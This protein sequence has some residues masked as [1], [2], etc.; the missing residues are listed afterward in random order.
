MYEPYWTIID[1]Y[2]ETYK[3]VLKGQAQNL[4]F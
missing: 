4:T 1:V 3:F 2:P